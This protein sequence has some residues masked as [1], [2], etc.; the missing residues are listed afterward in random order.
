MEARIVMRE[1]VCSKDHNIGYIYTSP[2][3]DIGK[4][5]LISYNPNMRLKFDSRL[6]LV[7]SCAPHSE[8]L[9]SLGESQLQALTKRPAQ[10]PNRYLYH[11]A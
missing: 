3:S 8:A 7:A 9:H 10:L 6:F 1:C 2:S 4:R 5:M 11:S